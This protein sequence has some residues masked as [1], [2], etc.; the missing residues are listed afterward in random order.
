MWLMGGDR[1][2]PYTDLWSSAGGPR[3]DQRTS[4]FVHSALFPP[5]GVGRWGPLCAVRVYGAPS[6]KRIS[7]PSLPHLSQ[8]KRASSEDTLNKPGVAAASG[9]AARLKKTSTSGAISELTESRLRG[10]SGRREWGQGE[11]QASGPGAGPVGRV[12][13]GAGHVGGAQGG[14]VQEALSCPFEN[15]SGLHS[16]FP[17]QVCQDH[18]E[19]GAFRQQHSTTGVYMSRGDRH[20]GTRRRWG[21]LRVPPPLCLSVTLHVWPSWGSRQG[22]TGRGAVLESWYCSVDECVGPQVPGQAAQPASWVLWR[23]ARSQGCSQS[24]RGQWPLKAV[25]ILCVTSF[26]R[27]RKGF[28]FFF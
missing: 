28:F 23:P 16:P 27:N 21:A 17:R 5:A 15:I 3:Q 22:G 11:T 2:R 24:L 19:S 12:R 9:A 10:P 20:K 8:L 14:G 4:G 25:G 18:F 26:L 13:G 6:R 1:P 7:S